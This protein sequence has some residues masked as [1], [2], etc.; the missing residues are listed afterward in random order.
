MTNEILNFVIK[1]NNDFS[2]KVNYDFRDK[3][4]DGIN[5]E[6]L[7]GINYEFNS[8]RYLCSILYHPRVRYFDFD[9]WDISKNENVLNK[10]TNDEKEIMETFEEMK[11][12]LK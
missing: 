9:I 10:S 2:S 7:Y 12:I 1:L 8:S 6:V 3:I 5:S 11:A 4:I